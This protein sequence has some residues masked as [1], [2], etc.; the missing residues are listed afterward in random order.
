M[1]IS[2]LCRRILISSVYIPVGAAAAR[3]SRVR[4]LFTY[5]SMFYADKTC[6]V[7]LLRRGSILECS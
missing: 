2:N 5:R 7:F 1:Y 4:R 3:E 6:L